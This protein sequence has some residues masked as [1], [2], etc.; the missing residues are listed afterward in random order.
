MR[1]DLA[2][3]ISETACAGPND[4]IYSTSNLGTSMPAEEGYVNRTGTSTA[5]PHV[6]GVVALLL[7]LS[8]RLSA[9]EVRAILTATARPHPKDTYCAM[10]GTGCGTGLLDANAA[11]QHVVNNRPTVTAVI[12]GSAPG[13]RP[14]GTFTLVGDIKAAGGRVPAATGASWRQ[15][16]GPTVTIPANAGATV[17]LTAPNSTGILVFEYSANDSAGY[18]GSAAVVVTVNAPPTM[19]PAPAATVVANHPLSGTVRGSDP[20]GDAITYVLAA[21][22]PG[23]TV[24]AATGAWSWTPTSAGTYGVTIVPTDAYGNGTP[25]AFAITVDKDPNAKDGGAGALPAWLALLLALA[26]VPRRRTA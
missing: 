25:V 24:N 5:A 15:V 22:P 26:C 2:G 11:V 23:L 6:S 18:A 10:G 14:G 21:G 17:T 9:D 12:Q 8:P 3:F 4:A 20:E 16:S 1:N 19:Q 7:A 13:A